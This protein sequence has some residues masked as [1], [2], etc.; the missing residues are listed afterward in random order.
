METKHIVFCLQAL[1]NSYGFAADVDKLEIMMAK[2]ESSAEVLLPQL[3]KTMKLR[4]KI[5]QGSLETIAELQTPAIV[6][7]S[8]NPCAL[9]MQVGKSEVIVVDPVER[10]SFSMTHADFFEFWSGWAVQVS[11]PYHWRRFSREFHLPWFG[12]VFSRFR[13]VL[14]EVLL[15]AFLLQCFGVITPL[16]TQVIVDKVLPSRGMATLDILIGIIFVSYLF[17]AFIGFLRTYIF[18]HTTNKLDTIF[19]VR[20]FRKVCSLPLRYFETRR[21]GD[22]VTRVRELEH[23]REFLTGSTITLLIDTLFSVVFFA[24]MAYYSLFLCMVALLATPVF[25][26]VAIYFGPR[27]QDQLRRKFQAY[28]ENYTFLVESLTGIQTVKSLALEPQFNRRW[29]ETTGRYVQ[30]SFESGNLSNLFG[31]INRL[32]SLLFNL[33]I[34]WVGANL[35]I[36]GEMTIGGLIAF[37]MLAGQAIGS[38]THV[39]GLWQSFQQARLSMAMLG[40][41]LHAPSEIAPAAPVALSGRAVNLQL[42]EVSFRYLAKTPPILAGVSLEIFAGQKVG[43]VGRSGSGKSTLAKLLQC[44]YKAESGSVKFCGEEVSTLNPAWLRRQI[45]VVL[46]DNFLFTGTIRD[47]IA[48]AKPGASMEEVLQVAKLAGAHEFIVDLPDGYDTVVN[49]GGNSLSGGQKQ[50]I[51]IARALM[52]N[53]PVLIFDEATSYLD[54][55]SERIVM[56]NLDQISSGRTVVMIAHRLSTVK[57]CDMIFV[58]DKG[59]VVERGMH[60]DLMARQGLYYWLYSQQSHRADA[61][62][63]VTG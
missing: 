58:M 12:S 24:V 15:M 48:I 32:T 28:R 36:G 30:L 11:E 19:G 7:L 62:S 8:G 59:Q 4:G 10:R 20:L 47:N 44:L 37:N 6:E 50:R 26:G 18:A 22:T 61:G 3:L 31:S 43:I 25:V 17:Q 23:V 14:S 27:I 42:H 1:A 54:Y 5:W 16:F 13:F 49:E 51:A 2:G 45:G 41:I 52:L 21:I 9:V 33:V 53:P 35:V 63:R 56:Q 55:E 39:A 57:R 34:L 29:E 38:V 46:Q 60:D 40:D